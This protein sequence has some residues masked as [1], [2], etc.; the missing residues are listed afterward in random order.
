MDDQAVTDLSYLR[1]MA[2]GD[3]DI[4]LDTAQVF[5]REIPKD[6]EQL[7]KH[8]V[9]QE[10]EKVG[11]IAHKIKPNMTYMGMERGRELILDIEKEA[12]SENISEKFSHQ[13]TEFKQICNRAIDELADKIEEIKANS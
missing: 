9:N 4:I 13:V 8:F 2:M 1:K 6:L 10:W 11:K 7:E 12:K 5:I 3:D